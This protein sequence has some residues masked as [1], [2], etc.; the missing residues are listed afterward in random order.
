MARIEFG[1]GIRK[2]KGYSFSLLPI[3]T[4]ENMLFYDRKQYEI[5]VGIW[6]WYFEISWKKNRFIKY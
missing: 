4:F 5:L 6:F 2:G 1:S 3:V